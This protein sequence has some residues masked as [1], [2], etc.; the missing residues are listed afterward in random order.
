MGTSTISMAIF[1]C[2]VSS[3]EGS[4]IENR[5][6]SGKRCCTRGK[7]DMFITVHLWF[8]MVP[9][10]VP[11][12]PCTS[13]SLIHAHFPM[14]ANGLWP[15]ETLTFII[16]KFSWQ[17]RWSS[18]PCSAR[19]PATCLSASLSRATCSFGFLDSSPKTSEEIESSKAHP[20]ATDRSIQSPVTYS[21]PKSIQIQTRPTKQKTSTK[22]PSKISKSS[23]SGSVLPPSNSP[24]WLRRSAAAAAD[25]HP[26]QQ[27]TPR[28]DAPVRRRRR[29]QRRRPQWVSSE[30]VSRRKFYRKPLYL[31]VKTNGFPVKI[32]P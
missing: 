23:A 27:G 25:R 26:T 13:S 21:N 7:N 32:F 16:S 22:I 4:M 14:G 30:D 3:P 31:M 6:S 28:W 1:N 17:L 20:K 18:S 8:P 2:Y 9:E 10:C 29:A 11:S 12:V 24:A 19:R 5:A 15:L